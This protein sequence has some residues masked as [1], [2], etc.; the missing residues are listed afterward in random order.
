MTLYLFWDIDGTLLTTARA[1]IF[2]LE[3][4][5]EE[6]LGERIDMRTLR[7]A[8]LTDAEIAREL[9]ASRGVRGPAAVGALLAAYERLLPERLG[10]RDGRVLPNVRENLDALAAR[11]DVVSMLLTGNIA[12][13]A[14]AKLRHYG[15]WDHFAD[16]GGAFSVEGSDR[17]SIARRARELAAE[18]GGDVPPGERMVVIGDTP[19]DVSCGKAIGARTVAV[20]TGPG[21]GLDELR[22]CAPDVVL[23]EL[24]GPEELMTLLGLPG[25]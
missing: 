10:W 8:G 6:V 22:A 13:G 1:G 4:A 19:H 9:C 2:A 25:A 16:T 18:H 12:G 7:T 20:A 5:S 15:L 17:P 21:Y 14:E 24:P 3:E 11:D 23:Q